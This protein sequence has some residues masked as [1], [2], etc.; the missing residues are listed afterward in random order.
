MCNDST[1][2]M[3]LQLVSSGENCQCLAHVL[4][5]G[6]NFVAKQCLHGPVP[7]RNKGNVSSTQTDFMFISCFIFFYIYFHVFTVSLAQQARLCVM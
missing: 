1:M 5:V 3:W 7:Q 2:N 6:G 4:I